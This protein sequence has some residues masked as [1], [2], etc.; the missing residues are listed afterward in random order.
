MD[1]P[2]AVTEYREAYMKYGKSAPKDNWYEKDRYKDH[3]DIRRNIMS[4]VGLSEYHKIRKKDIIYPTIEQ[5]PKLTTKVKKVR[6]QQ[7]TSV[8]RKLKLTEYDRPS[9]NVNEKPVESITNKE[10]ARRS[11]HN[12]LRNNLRDASRKNIYLPDASAEI[13]PRAKVVKSKGIVKRQI[14]RYGKDKNVEQYMEPDNTVSMTAKKYRSKPMKSERMPLRK[15]T[16]VFDEEAKDRITEIK[17]KNKRRDKSDPV[18]VQ[19]IEDDVVFRK[20]EGEINQPTVKLSDLNIKPISSGI[21]M[22][23]KYSYKD[24]IVDHDELEPGVKLFRSA[25]QNIEMEENIEPENPVIA[26]F[27]DNEEIIPEGKR[28]P[29]MNKKDMDK[30]M[31]GMSKIRDREDHLVDHNEVG[32]SGM[33]ALLPGESVTEENIEE[34]YKT[35]YV[36]DYDEST[37]TGRFTNPKSDQH[38]YV[39]RRNRFEKNIDHAE[40]TPVVRRKNKIDKTIDR[41]CVKFGDIVDHDECVP[42]MPIDI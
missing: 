37:P 21:L 10:T 14:K 19:N 13:E 5:N 29:L 15:L 18:Y 36:E 22:N 38:L 2:E 17:I 28:G 12:L 8:P 6:Y 20:Y 9:Y 3:R 32:G 41:D 16:D 33:N 31:R 4:P 7:R 42:E 34:E 39:K 40:I 26:F 30:S 1:T 11:R 35:D 25:K 24:G 27:E 23:R